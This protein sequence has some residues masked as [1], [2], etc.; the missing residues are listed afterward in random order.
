MAKSVVMESKMDADLGAGLPAAGGIEDMDM[1]IKKVASTS[2]KVEVT[3]EVETEEIDDLRLK[4]I[5]SLLS[6]QQEPVSVSIL[7]SV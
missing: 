2:K 6:L 1:W 3:L 5:K 4:Q 7:S